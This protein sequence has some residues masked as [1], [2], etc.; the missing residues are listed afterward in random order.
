MGRKVRGPRAFCVPAVNEWLMKSPRHVTER[1][2]IL[3]LPTSL[4]CAQKGEPVKARLIA[5]KMPRS[6][7]RGSCSL[8]C[9]QRWTSTAAI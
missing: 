4:V 8:E 6:V 9:R 3:R 1:G 5:K 7:K 2:M